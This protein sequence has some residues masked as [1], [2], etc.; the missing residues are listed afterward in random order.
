MSQLDLGSDVC[1][2]ELIGFQVLQTQDIDSGSDIE[3]RRYANRIPHP[4]CIDIGGASS[5][6][7]IASFTLW[8]LNFILDV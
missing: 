4:I 1:N 7:P 5:Y 8:R 3:S 2:D 6:R